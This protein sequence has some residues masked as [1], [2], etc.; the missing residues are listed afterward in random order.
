MFLGIDAG[1]TE[2]KAVVVNINGEVLGMGAY[3]T[4]TD[5]TEAA[6]KAVALALANAGADMDSVKSAVSTGYGRNIQGLA[7][8]AKTEISCHGAGAFKY[9]PEPLT[10]IDI[11]GQDSKIIKIG[12]KGEL[13]DF[14]M[15]RKCAAGTGAFL[16][17]TSRRMG[18]GIGEMNALAANSTQKVELGSYC[19]VFSFSEI[20]SLSRKG[21]KK[22]DLARAVYVSMV[23]R[24]MEMD[25]FAGKVVITGGAVEFNPVLIE[26]FKEESGINALVPPSP[27]FAGAL[28]AALFAIKEYNA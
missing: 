25:T 26:I 21:V 2:A 11:G 7:K 23:K 1:S 6:E 3:R 5:F 10:V 18:S 15:N 12:A 19:T 28:G 14:K 4:W 17:E 20:L 22:E 27:R 8:C 9:F 13:L 24:I 16:E